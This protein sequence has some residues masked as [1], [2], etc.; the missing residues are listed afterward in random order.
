VHLIGDIAKILVYNVILS[1]AQ[2]TAV[3]QYLKTKYAIS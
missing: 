1:T 2:V 3:E